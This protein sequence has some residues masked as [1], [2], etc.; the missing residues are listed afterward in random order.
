M[1]RLLCAYRNASLR[2]KLSLLVTAVLLTVLI[3]CQVA[4][5]FYVA[6]NVERQ[7]RSAADVTLTQAQ[8]YMDAKLRNVVE[9]LFYI[10]LDPSFE[11]ALT[12]YLLSDK[13]S[14]QGVAMT[15]LSPCLSLHKVTE[16]LIS[17][18]FLYTPKSSFTDMGVSTEQEYRFEASVL[19]RQAEE[20]E[21]YVI[22]GEVQKDEIFITH[23]EVL[24]VMYRFSVDGYGGDCVLLANIDKARLTAYLHDI[25]PDDGSD[26]LLVDGRGRL[27]TQAGGAAAAALAEDYGA[28]H[29]VL[30]T[31]GFTETAAQGGKYL[32]A[33]RALANAP[34]HVV[35]LQ[36]EKHILGQLQNIR[37]VFFAVSL[38]VVLVLLVAL[39]RIVHSVTQPL[40]R[41]S[42]R[43]RSVDVKNDW[44][45][46]EYPYHNEI[47]TLSRSFN[48]MLAHIHMLL[49]EQ[50]TYIAQL[51]DEKERVRVEQQLK[52]RAELKALQAQI[53]PHFLYNTLDSIRWKAER[54]GAGYQ[55]N[56]NGIGDA[57][58]YRAEPR[59][60]DH[61]RGAGSAACGQLS[62]DSEAA[63]R[64][65][66]ELYGGAFA[67]YP[68]ALYR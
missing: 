17:S 31:E 29:A 33:H 43:M 68:A 65:K 28:L 7:A 16:P 55:P 38:A 40:S 21:S 19:W 2:V 1:K 64:R 62:A 52:R 56:D 60:R 37:N 26:M 24:P 30:E 45:G 25:V 15:L 20:S 49:D 57:V 44:Q 61:F 54:A 51:Q 10:R 47:G 3:A 32:T 41:L 34:W 13:P 48:S 5:Y 42:Q 58:P 46:F 9:R 66:A 18:I 53:N 50:E 14:A 59:Q 8:T 67:G 12:D 36:S 35:Y 23:R 27:V 63:L 6:E 39:T 11:G 4:L 22:W